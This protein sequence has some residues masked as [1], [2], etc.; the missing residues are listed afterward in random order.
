MTILYKRFKHF[1]RKKLKLINGKGSPP[2]IPI[3][4]ARGFTAALGKSLLF[5]AKSTVPDIPSI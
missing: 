5:G 2:Y 3:A 4:K 1:Y